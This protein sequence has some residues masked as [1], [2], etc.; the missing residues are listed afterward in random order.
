MLS[1]NE[2]RLIGN[3]GKDPEIRAMQN[4]REVAN[5]SLATSERWKDKSGQAQERTEWHRVA[6]F[7]PGLVKAIKEHYAKGQRVYVEGKLQTRSWEKNGQTHHT[8]EIVV[9]GLSGKVRLVD[10]KPGA[11]SDVSDEPESAAA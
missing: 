8:T 7:V 4:G 10:A 5:L 2:V 6:V 3:L 1:L 11:E 9:E